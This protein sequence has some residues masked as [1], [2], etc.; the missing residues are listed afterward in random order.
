MVVPSTADGF[1]ASVSALRSIDG[2]DGVNFHTTLPEDR[3][4]RVLVKN[5]VRGMSESVVREKLESLNICVQGV[6]QLRSG[7]RDQDPAKDR[8]PTPTS[9]YQWRE[10]LRWPRYDHSQNSA[11]C[12]CWL[13]RRW[14]QRVHCSAS[15]VRALDTRSVTAVTYPGSSRVWASTSPVDDPPLGN[16]CVVPTRGTTVDV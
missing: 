1:R 9:L 16:S 8:P 15:A 13:S 2:K 12:D 3:R 4:A 11:T 5:L 14:L 10:G 7:R 6:T